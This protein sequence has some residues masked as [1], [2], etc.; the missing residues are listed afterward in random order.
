MK[1]FIDIIIKFNLLFVIIFVKRFV[2]SIKRIFLLI[3]KAFSWLFFSKE[4]TNF[5]FELENNSFR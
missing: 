2:F 4:H 1:K 3:R 5:S